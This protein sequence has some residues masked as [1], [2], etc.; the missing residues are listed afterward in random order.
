MI[1]QPNPPILEVLG[2]TFK[3]DQEHV[4]ILNNITFD[5][6]ANETILVLGASGSGKSTLAYCLNNIYPSMVDGFLSGSIKFRGQSISSFEPGKINQKIGLVMQDPDSQF[7]MLTVEEEIAFVLENIRFP[8]LEMKERINY[9]LDL[10][11][12]KSFK[13]S[14]I[15]SLSGGQKQK[16]AIACAL[17]M[18]PELLILDEPTANLDP[19]SGFEL[20]QVLKRLRKDHSFS[21]VVIE[22]NLDYWLEI[23][24]RCVILSSEGELLFNGHPNVCFADLAEELANEGIW[25]PRPIEAGM[26]LRE[27][28]LLSSSTL[29]MTINEIINNSKDIAKTIEFLSNN[30]RRHKQNPS[31]SIFD[32]L[33]VS[34][35]KDRQLIIKDICLSINKGEFIAIAG[36]NGSGKTTFSKCLA[37]LISS[38]GRI[39]F[40]GQSLE[41]WSEELKWSRLGYVFQNPE[42]QFITDSVIEEINYSLQAK[43]PTSRMYREKDILKTLRMAEQIYSHP[44]SLSQGQKRRLS[45]AVML[46][47][48]QEV[49]IMD[50][51]TFGQDAITSQEIIDFAVKA[52]PE[53]GSII[54]ITHDMDLIDRFADKVLVLEKGEVIFYE[55]PSRLWNLPEILARAHLRLPFLREIEMHLGG[56]YAVK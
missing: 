48:G 33:D 42:H 2:L 15:Q 11:G 14:L 50:E 18:E 21:I 44:F 17:A 4:P 6:K 31:P 54:M 41:D 9:A 20:V 19:A 28:G 12:M 43:D 8:R 13:Q 56:R 36:A 51:P 37:G 35:S 27:A 34:Y 39:K 24:D 29:P 26:K 3:F 23:V 25:L 32:V 10:V 47:N 22:H 53:T 46:L 45:V 38:Q 49:L 7:C 16:L 30:T 5:I 1:S 52:V 55:S 40:Y